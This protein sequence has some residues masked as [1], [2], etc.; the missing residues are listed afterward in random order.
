MLLTGGGNFMSWDC[1]DKGQKRSCIWLRPFSL[2]T[3]WT[4]SL[5]QHQEAELCQGWG[6][7][8]APGTVRW[9][10]GDPAPQ[11]HLAPT[12]SSAETR[13]D[14]RVCWIFTARFMSSLQWLQIKLKPC[15]FTWWRVRLN[16]VSAEKVKYSILYLNKASEALMQEA[17]I[18]VILLWKVQFVPE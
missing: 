7:M 18:F 1:A 8:Q 4:H 16:S 5:L 11:E 15:W 9:L 12:S 3:G 14:H 13:L 10:F 2:E 17:A 6:L